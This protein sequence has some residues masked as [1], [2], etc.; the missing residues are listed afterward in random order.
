ML[1]PRSAAGKLDSSE[2]WKI[3]RRSILTVN[4]LAKYQQESALKYQQNRDNL[5]HS[6]LWSN[7][8]AS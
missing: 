5:E 1:K 3:R 2:V 7:T 6:H 4:S 8:V